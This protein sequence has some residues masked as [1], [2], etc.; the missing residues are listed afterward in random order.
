MQEADTQRLLPRLAVLG[1]IVAALGLPLNDLA[2]YALLAVSALLVLTGRIVRSPVRW[3]VAAALAL[4]VA[5]QHLFL[6]APRIEE[7]HNVFL[8]DGTGSA[9]E[10]GLPADVFAVMAQRFNAAYPPQQRCKAGEPLCWR[11]D[12]IPDRLF[13]FA[14]DGAFAHPAFTRRVSG[15]DFR[16]PIWLRLG[17]VNDLSLNFVGKDGDVERLWRDRRSLALFGRWQNRL[18][19]FLMYRFPPAFEG[20]ALCWSGDVLW[21]GQGERFE[22][23][24]HP[25]W[26]CRPLRSEDIGRRIFAFSIGPKADLAMTLDANVHIRLWRATDAAVAAIGVIGILLLLLR[27]Q[28]L[29]L[30]FPLL[31]IVPALATIILTDATFLGGYRT[32]DGGDDGLI[33]SGFARR[34]LEHLVHGDIAGALQGGENVFFFT[35]GMRYFR[36]IEYLIFGDSYLGYLSVM[37]IAPLVVYAIFARFLGTRWAFVITLAFVLTPVGMLFGTSY[38]HYAVWSARGFAD[39][40]AATIFLT[41]LVALAGPRG[42]S[43]DARTRPAFWGGLMMALAV[44]VR[45]NLVPGAAVLLAG[46]GLAALW[47]TRFAR[48]AALCAGFAPV[49]FMPWHNWHFGGRLVPIGDNATAQNIW[50]VPPSVW[51]SALR[52]IARLD[53][54]GENLARAASQA[55]LFLSGPSELR[56]LIPLHLAAFALAIRVACA[57]RFEPML[58]LAALAALALSTLGYVYLVSVRY[59]LV[60]WML[61]TLVVVAWFQIEGL[62]LIVRYRPGWRDRMARSPSVL[63]A[64]RA[65]ARLQAFVGA[66]RFSAA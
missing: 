33:F 11:P 49:L 27:V 53:F 5:A 20:S 13:A 55:A 29:R 63:G 8:I 39:P 42:I 54:A 14:A 38:F 58:R 24:D 64:G 12:G 26:Q 34:M 23:V 9:L 41:G 7:G 6:S 43:S 30:R 37:L 3:T 15:I 52:E 35:P 10:R 60:M 47:H 56:L 2:V 18:P 44:V 4:L 65:L 19:Y 16:N 22:L 57:R 61:L 25:S 59:H 31:L 51:W 17:V 32:L 66:E 21:E 1:L 50:I 45:P 36:M 28:P 46:A 48:L 40:L 62:A